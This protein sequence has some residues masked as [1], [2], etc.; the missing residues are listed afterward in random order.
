MLVQGRPTLLATMHVSHVR[1]LAAALA[2]VMWDSRAAAM[3]LRVSSAR[4][5]VSTRWA[6]RAAS[7]MMVGSV[8][9]V[10]AHSTMASGPAGRGLDAYDSEELSWLHRNLPSMSVCEADREDVSLARDVAIGHRS[11]QASFEGRNASAFKSDTAGTQLPTRRVGAR[12]DDAQ[13]RLLLANM[14][15]VLS[16]A[17]RYRNKGVS[18][19]DLV[20]E[21]CLGM[22]HA[23]HKFDPDRGVKFVTFAYYWVHQYLSRAVANKGYTIRLPVYVH[24]SRRRL[25]QA[26]EA[27]LAEGCPQ[28]SDEEVAQRANLPLRRV[29][30]LHSVP[31]V[32][33]LDAAIQGHRPG[34]SATAT[35][36]AGRG[37]ARVA[38]GGK[39]AA[40]SDLLA[41]PRAQLPDEVLQER[42]FRA[43]LDAVLRKTL[44]AKQHQILRLRY[45][46]NDGRCVPAPSARTPRTARACTRRVARARARPTDVRRPSFRAHWRASR[47]ARP[48]RVSEI[49]RELNLDAQV[50]R[51]AEKSALAK[52]RKTY[53][54]TTRPRPRLRA[55]LKYRSKRTT[56]ALS[57]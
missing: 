36:T 44:N 16:L 12:T 24:E 27:L 30:L 46:L 18:L 6:S 34:A 5:G 13:S 49:S 9:R 22:L 41:D 23:M 1:V 26:R 50:V 19:S 38:T 57:E 2:A 17:R 31:S 11:W 42:M 3:M 8:Q 10:R 15:L 53:S 51:R 40:M 56:P 33:S 54:E 37:G 4:V 45:G 48:K 32:V 29:A 35:Q 39:V 43:Q 21:G 20:Q 28:P 52:L 25:Q 14:G 55:Q 47:C 7:P